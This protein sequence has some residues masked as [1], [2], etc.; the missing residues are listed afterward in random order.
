MLLRP[1]LNLFEAY[2]WWGYLLCLGF[3]AFQ[4]S[5]HNFQVQSKALQAKWLW[6]TKFI[7]ETR[8]VLL[9]LND[10]LYF[11]TFHLQFRWNDPI[12]DVSSA[13]CIKLTIH[14]DLRKSIKSRWNFNFSLHFEISHH[15]DYTCPYRELSFR[16]WRG[17][18]QSVRSVHFHWLHQ[19]DN[20]CQIDY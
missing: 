11:Q 3:L 15:E 8:K 14:A 2:F 6:T 17:S 5:N 13:A 19:G 7:K 10:D 12:S 1:L 20:L 16:S 18:S 9:S 4:M